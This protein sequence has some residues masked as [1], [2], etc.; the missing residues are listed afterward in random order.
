MLAHGDVAAV[1]AV[2]LDYT[3][4]T[5]FVLVLVT[6]SVCLLLPADLADADGQEDEEQ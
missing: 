1:A 4:V 2:E 3:H 6:I 5:T